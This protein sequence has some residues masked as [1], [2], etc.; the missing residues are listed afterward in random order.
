[1][2]CVQN[3]SQNVSLFHHIDITIGFDRT[4][5]SVSEN[6]ASITVFVEVK[7]NGMLQRSV[8]VNYST[9]ISPGNTAT[10]ELIMSIYKETVVLSCLEKTLV[11]MES[12]AGSRN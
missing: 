3:D 9:P 8:V 12:M 6:A 7:D 2:K 4:R 11:L 5:D 10:S 1:M